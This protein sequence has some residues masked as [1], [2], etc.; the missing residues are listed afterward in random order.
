MK[1][2]GSLVVMGFI[3]SSCMAAHADV[4]PPCP[5]PAGVTAV[6]L[7]SGLPYA[8]AGDVAGRLRARIIAL[9]GER[10]DSTDVAITGVNARYIFAW[11]VESAW[12]VA[13]EHGG[14]AYNDQILRYESS[15]D[16]NG[17]KMTR[18]QIAFP[19]TVCAIATA[20]AKS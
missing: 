11:K 4:I 3:L 7:P 5:A 16:G 17:F 20:L 14:L 9:P 19:G 2:H 12:I 18:G 8:I 10:F 6:S 15:S 13:V 1:W